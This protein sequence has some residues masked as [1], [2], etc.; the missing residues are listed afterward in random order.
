MLLHRFPEEFQRGLAISGLRH[1][2]FEKLALPD[3]LSKSLIG[4]HF[5]ANLSSSHSRGGTS[6]QGS[7]ERNP[8]P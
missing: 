3:G 5:S 7:H 4:W 6:G 8:F 1:E 2:A